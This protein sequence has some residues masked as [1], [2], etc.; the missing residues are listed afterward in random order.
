VLAILVRTA[1]TPVRHNTGGIGAARA[2]VGFR[3]LEGGTGARVVDI[4]H[5]A[6]DDLREGG[7]ASQQRQSRDRKRE[8]T[9]PHGT[10][11]L[12]ALQLLP[13]PTPHRGEPCRALLWLSNRERERAPD[14][15]QRW[16]TGSVAILVPN[17][18]KGVKG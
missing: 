18:N 3:D 12:L 9:S 7:N 16:H 6:V 8:K 5:A 17:T 1:E 10:T 15:H 4:D 13:R 14:R 2:R 11:Y